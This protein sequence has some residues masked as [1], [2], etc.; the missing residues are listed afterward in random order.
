MIQ[1]RNHILFYD[2]LLVASRTHTEN[3]RYEEREREDFFQS[4]KWEVPFTIF[5]R[6]FKTCHQDFDLY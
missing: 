1:Q 5:L 2:D 3:D 4:S 6:C